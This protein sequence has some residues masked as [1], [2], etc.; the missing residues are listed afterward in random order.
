MSDRFPQVIQQQK[1]S[2]ICAYDLS[3]T[4]SRH[5]QIFS[6]TLV[7][8]KRK[9]RA[10]KAIANG[11]SVRQSKLQG[12][13]GN[14][15]DKESEESL[16]VSSA[17]NSPERDAS[18]APGQVAKDVK[19]LATSNPFAKPATTNPFAAPNTKPSQSFLAPPTAPTSF[20]GSK[21][22]SP[23]PSIG[24][25]S[26]ATKPLSSFQTPSMSNEQIA[27]TVF[28]G[29]I[30]NSFTAPQ[31]QAATGPAKPDLTS[32][33]NSVPKDSPF[34]SSSNSQG[35]LG[36]FNAVPKFGQLFAPSGSA[37]APS[38]QAG[39]S[40]F[41]RIEKPEESSKNSANDKPDIA[42]E[43][44]Q[45]SFAL[46]TTQ[47]QASASNVPSSR[48]SEAPM[49]NQQPP[50]FQRPTFQLPS[51]AADTQQPS[52]LFATGASIAASASP[53]PQSGFNFAAA[54]ATQQASSSSADEASKSRISPLTKI[55]S[56]SEKT[57]LA[58]K[59]KQPDD[60][61]TSKFASAFASAAFK[62]Q[63][64]PTTQQ[65]SADSEPFKNP[66][67]NLISEVWKQD[68]KLGESQLSKNNG[69]V[70]SLPAKTTFTEDNKSHTPQSTLFG[71]ASKS[72]LP[73]PSLPSS[74]S[75]SN[76]S[77]MFSH[78]QANS[79]QKSPE[80]PF[81]TNTQTVLM[82]NEAQVRSAT[83]EKLAQELLCEDWG[84]LE[85]FT[86]NLM[87]EIF[88]DSDR[89]V[90][91]EREQEKY[92][93]LRSRYLSTK[94]LALWRQKTWKL[95]LKRR[96]I[97]RRKSLRKS[98][99][100]LTQQ[101]EEFR[102]S[103]IASDSTGSSIQINGSIPLGSLLSA[104]HHHHDRI[105]AESSKTKKRKSLQ[106]DDSLEYDCAT[107]GDTPT[108]K[109]FVF[110]KPKTSHHRRTQ[111][112]GL[113]LPSFP[114]TRESAGAERL[115]ASL[116]ET[117]RQFGGADSLLSESMLKRARQ[118]IGKTDTTRTDYFRLKARGINPN[119]PLVPET[120]K[121]SRALTES[122]TNTPTPDSGS[123]A[124]AIKLSPPTLASLSAQTREFLSRSQSTNISTKAPPT[125]TSAVPKFS[126]DE[127][128]LLAQARKLRETL[129]E[130]ETWFRREREA[131]EA[132]TKPKDTPPKGETEKQRK[133]REWQ[134][135]PSKTSIRLEKTKA[136]GLLPDGWKNG[137]AVNGDKKGKEREVIEDEGLFTPKQK[138]RGMAPAFGTTQQLRGFAALAN[139][140]GNVPQMG[141]GGRGSFGQQRGFGSPSPPVT[142]GASADD[143]IEL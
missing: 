51:S 68:G 35:S 41:D 37:S 110:K 121:R 132:K 8:F 56:G 1:F 83:L 24:F 84:F 46:F 93:R 138:D 114:I 97:H 62:S 89:I 108:Q 142:K 123:A 76:A 113:S 16:F 101:A 112:M 79:S 19:S 5:E 90:T 115:R 94:Y 73:Q 107:N 140:T 11:L 20:G 28:P 105:V 6:E 106:D 13:I 137:M 136:G 64:K 116:G 26:S 49:L 126:S 70:S 50:Q 124:K 131:I 55:D 10:F 85:Q 122:T 120:R 130:G 95:N 22:S 59:F 7:E 4:I 141:M 111:T 127:E 128:S 102:G 98:L 92:A 119:T 72:L 88:E 86:E 74:S 18:P 44:K 75:A 60:S 45:S 21:E 42:Q 43:T 133:L 27:Q 78:H 57:D 77:T 109:P 69:G 23:L 125:P 47:P 135:T 17:S 139:G 66:F 25:G 48:G 104:P 31:S 36:G 34:A 63:P 40:L 61:Q 39:K 38:P 82:D 91:R 53:F 52:S 71:S 129:A 118:V 3:D 96:A 30:S 32:I 58:S 12:L 2:I 29:S 33:F 80:R 14:D 9:H 134:A 117:R 103:S 81:L 54:S 100:D 67:Q 143:A 15:S 99:R 65:Q 87:E